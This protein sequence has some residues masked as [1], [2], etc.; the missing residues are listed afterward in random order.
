LA[1]CV[2][3]REQFLRRH[4]RATARVRKIRRVWYAAALL[5][6]NITARRKLLSTRSIATIIDRSQATIEWVGAF[7]HL[8]L[9][10]R[11]KILARAVWSM[12]FYQRRGN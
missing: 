8:A 11:G 7:S 12:T 6:R 4:Q 10:F 3:L 5:R 1:V 2:G 9:A